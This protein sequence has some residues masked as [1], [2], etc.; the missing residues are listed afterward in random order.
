LNSDSF[1]MN[2]VGRKLQAR[3]LRTAFVFS[4]LAA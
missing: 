3:V 1:S 4:L 2:V